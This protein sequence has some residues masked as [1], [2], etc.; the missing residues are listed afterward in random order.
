[1]GQDVCT[2]VVLTCCL[3][4]LL[5]YYGASWHILPGSIALAAC[6]L[7][8]NIVGIIL[9]RRI[10]LR[11]KS[12]V[13]NEVIE[14]FRDWYP[15]ALVLVVYEH[16]SVYAGIIRPEVIDPLLAHMEI[17]I[18]SVQ[19]TVWIE[20]FAHPLA[21]D[22]MSVA[23]AFHFPLTFGLAYGLYVFNKRAYYRDFAT[24]L[25]FCNFAG[26]IL[27]LVFPAGPPRFFL[28]S[29]YHTIPLPSYSG[30]YTWAEALWDANN[31][32]LIH[33]S[34]PSLHVAFSTV[35]LIYA[36]R[37]AH[38]P[39]IRKWL[40]PVVTLMAVSLWASTIYLRHHWTPDILAGWLLGIISVVVARYLTSLLN[41]GHSY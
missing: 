9:F 1:M 26:F 37:K 10:C 35:T 38:W 3:S 27:Y 21:V 8:C 11:R 33:S 19:P 18:W 24:A 28:E 5:F 15:F 41:P 20:Q 31:P 4:G 30:L 17:Q 13:S 39:D 6:L 16:L 29:A 12:P 23:Y 2:L 40:G 14:I 36:F 25:L 7:A 34:F 22:L 32:V